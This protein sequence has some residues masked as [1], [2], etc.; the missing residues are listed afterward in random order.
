MRAIDTNVLVRLITRDDPG[1]VTAAEA[2][3]ANGAWVS[4]LVLAEATWVLS[5]VYHLE[6]PE[7]AKMVEMLLYHKD[8]TLEGSEVVTAAL[9][10]FRKKP[11]LGFSDCLL[12]EIARKAGHTPLGTFDQGLGRLP[13]AQKL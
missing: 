13:G 10:H 5:A 11:A 7:I 4:Y 9:E 8:L 6:P 1:Q 2:F 12:L 3:V